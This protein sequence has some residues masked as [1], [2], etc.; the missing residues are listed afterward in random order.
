M[1]AAYDLER[2]AAVYPRI[3]IADS[4]SLNREERPG[5]W[6]VVRDQDGFRL[7]DVFY[8]IRH[9]DRDDTT[10]GSRLERVRRLIETQLRVTTASPDVTA[11]WQWLD[12]RFRIDGR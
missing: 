6:R 4:L 12:A 8:R 11:K 1:I 5:H 2:G 9:D 7:L 10:A 3:V